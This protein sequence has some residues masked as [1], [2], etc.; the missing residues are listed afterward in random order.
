[1]PVN[2]WCASRSASISALS[3]VKNLLKCSS[4][5][6]FMSLRP[7]LNTKVPLRLCAVKKNT[8]WTPFWWVL[9]K[10]GL[11][12]HNLSCTN[13]PCR[14]HQSILAPITLVQ[15]D[16]SQQGKPKATGH[17]SCRWVS[18]ATVTCLEL[19][20]DFH[21]SS[22]IWI[23]PRRSFLRRGSTDANEKTLSNRDLLHDGGWHPLPSRAHPQA[24]N[25]TVKTAEAA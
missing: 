1:M 12:S 20:P 21:Q 2:L 7:S 17:D 11:R 24:W 23:P 3:L 13:L 9:N 25:D 6:S 19:M 8:L 22:V 4:S 10:H 14:L 16:V 15:W 5:V 18:L